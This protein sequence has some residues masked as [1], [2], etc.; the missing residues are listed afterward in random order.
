MVRGGP[1]ITQTGHSGLIHVS[2]TPAW[3]CALIERLGGKG[4]MTGE[5]IQGD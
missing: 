5:R 1:V 4:P 3:K 2:P